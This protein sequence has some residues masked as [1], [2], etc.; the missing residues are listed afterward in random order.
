MTIFWPKNLSSQAYLYI[1]SVR[2]KFDRLFKM[3][4]ANNL[5]RS[6]VQAIVNK[7]EY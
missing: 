6:V 4:Q 1:K 3:T 7:Q 5:S 2:P